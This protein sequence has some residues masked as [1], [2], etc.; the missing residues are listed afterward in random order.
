MASDMAGWPPRGRSAAAIRAISLRWAESSSCQAAL[1]LLTFSPLMP[2]EA[3]RRPYS[4][5]GARSS[6]TL[7]PSKKMDRPQEPRSMEPSGLPHSSPQRMGREGLECRI[8]ENL[9]GARRPSRS[10]TP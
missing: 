6:R 1:T 10:N 8:R 9:P 5:P 4:A 2:I 7:P 3:S